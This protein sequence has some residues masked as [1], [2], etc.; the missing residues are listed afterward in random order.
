MGRRSRPVLRARCSRRWPSDLGLLDVDVPWSKLQGSTRRS[1]STA[2]GQKQGA[3]PVQEPLRPGPLA[4]PPATRACI[5]WLQRRH[6]EA[7]SDAHPGADRGLH[8]GGAV[9]R[10]RRRPAAPGHPGR[11]HRR[12]EHLRGLPACRSARPP[13][14][15]PGST[16]SERDRHDR[17][18]GR[19]RRST[20]GCGS[21]S[22]SAST[23][24]AGPV[25][26]HAGRRRGPAHPAG[27]P[28]RQ[29]A[30]SAC[31]TC[32]TSRRSACT[33]ATTA[34]SSTRCIRLRDLGNTVIV[35]EHD[36]DTIRVADHVVDI[37]PGRGEHGGEV[38]VDGHGEG[39]AG[40]APRRSPA[41]YLS[42][43]RSDPGAR[44]APGA[45]RALAHGQGRPGAQPAP[46]STWSSRSAA[47]SPSPACQ[48]RGQVDAGQRHPVPRR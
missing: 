45:R 14:S 8:A 44:D 19:S 17:R 10:V 23:T 22:T 35:V 24:Y 33:S 18:A 31:C 28:D 40:R 41:Q 36:E 1:C 46:T 6:A 13:S 38:V 42:G 20:P 25:G 27:V 30:W 29:R 3:G 32:S 12:A 2:P 34:A 37:G 5:P 26:G 43:R 16:L 7:E 21:C 39:P 9:P 15:S 48:R 11:H 4:T 47:S